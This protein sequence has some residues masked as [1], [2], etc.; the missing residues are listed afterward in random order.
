[1]CKCDCG[2]VMCVQSQFVLEGMTKT[3]SLG[4]YRH[5]TCRVQSQYSSNVISLKKLKRMK[6]AGHVAGMG[7]RKGANGFGE[8][9]DGKKTT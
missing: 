8:R 1:M 3:L 5:D 7:D 9:P 4:C 6:W 2:K